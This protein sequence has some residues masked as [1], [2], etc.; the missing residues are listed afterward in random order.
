MAA[1]WREERGPG[2]SE[3]GWCGCEVT[4]SLCFLGVLTTERLRESENGELYREKGLGLKSKANL[5]G[6]GEI[7]AGCSPKRSSVILL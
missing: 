7:G 3:Q 2:S 6:G 4:L 5:S 1:E